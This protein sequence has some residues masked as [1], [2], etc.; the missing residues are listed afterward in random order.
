MTVMVGGATRT[1]RDRRVRLRDAR[2]YLVTESRIGTARVESVVARALA[3]GVDVVQLRD[4]AASD[5]EVAGAARRLARLCARHGALLIVNDRPDLAL[6]AGADGV[7]LGQEDMPVEAARRVTGPALLIG[8]STHSPAQVDAA[9]ASGA[10]YLG[11]GPVYP[12]AT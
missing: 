2:L 6:E 5:S 7:H 3:A 12:T 10:D 4:K 11:V 8:L 9:A 1:G